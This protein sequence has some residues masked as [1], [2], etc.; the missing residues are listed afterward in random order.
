MGSDSN[1]DTLADLHQESA[2]ARLPRSFAEG[3]VQH[4]IQRGNNR[5]PTFASEQDIVFY[6]DCLLRASQEHGI[7]VHAYV[8]MTNH[9]HLLVTP[10]DEHSLPK[11][12]QS[13]GRRYVQ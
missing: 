2:M 9:V 10:Q 3:E 12:M 4:V 8:L 5:E 13:I 1:Y 11:T 7:A 6:L